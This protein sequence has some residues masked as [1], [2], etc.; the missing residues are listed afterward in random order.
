MSNQ[1][2]HLYERDDVPKIKKKISADSEN[3][4]KM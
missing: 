3:I 2:W 1:Q 4:G